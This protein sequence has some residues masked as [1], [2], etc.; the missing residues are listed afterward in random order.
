MNKS[1][2]A[3]D[4]LGLMGNCIPGLDRARVQAAYQDVTNLTNEI[5][6]I[7]DS[8]GGPELGDVSLLTE[9]ER[10]ERRNAED[11]IGTLHKALIEFANIYMTIL[12]HEAQCRPNS[13]CNIGKLAQM[14]SAS[15]I[16]ADIL[17]RAYCLYVFRNKII[18][19][20]E[21]PRG[22][23]RLRVRDGTR[24][25]WPMGHQQ[26]GMSPATQAQL[27]ALKSRYASLSVVVAQ[28]NN[29]FEL[30][31]VLFYTIPGPHGAAVSADR[32]QINSIA[33]RGGCRSMTIAEIIAT[34]DD[35]SY[36][37]ARLAPF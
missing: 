11:R 28:E 26:P 9:D 10:V 13:E 27:V 16:A 5:A 1:D 37:I 7:D 19:H 25:L 31:T 23:G 32:K 35:F 36:D 20:H 30:L 21:V 33:E 8:V 29:P 22:M 4:V 12:I 24:W 15:K 6:V 3:R 2:F 34:V 17:H 18:V 14:P